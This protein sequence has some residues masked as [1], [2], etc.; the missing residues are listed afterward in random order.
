VLWDAIVNELSHE[1]IAKKHGWS[2]PEV[3]RQ[4]LHQAR[5][6]IAKLPLPVVTVEIDEQ[7]GTRAF[8]WNRSAMDPGSPFASL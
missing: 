3:S 8:N 6:A 5:S 2:S 1:E 7:G 4:K